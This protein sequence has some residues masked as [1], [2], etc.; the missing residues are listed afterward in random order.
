MTCHPHYQ[1]HLQIGIIFLL[2]FSWTS[3]VQAQQISGKVIDKVGEALIGVNIVIKGD[4]SRGTTTDF[5]GS[6]ELTANQGETLVFSYTG[7]LT[8]EILIGTQ[9]SFDLT[10]E[11]NVE[12][13]DE[14]VVIGY[15]V[16]KKSD[17]TG[18]V[19]SVDVGDVQKLA[20]V[21]VT[22]NL[23][24]KVAG[25][26]I[27]PN[28]GAPGVGSSVRIRGVGSFSNADPLYVVDGFLTGD[29]S[30][31]APTDIHSIEVLKDASATAIYG[32][33]GANGVILITTKKGA[34]GEA[35]I[36]INSYVGTQ[37]PW[38]T[39]DL[40]N[41]QQYAEIY[42]EAVAG[43]DGDLNGIRDP[44]RRAWIEAA[45]SGAEPGTDWQDYIFRDNAIIQSHNVS[46][47]GSEGKIKY[48]A[49][50]T[51]FDQEGIVHLTEGRRIQAN[52]GAEMDVKPFLTLGGDLKYS[53]NTAVAFDESAFGGPLTSALVKDPI[54]P[55][56]NYITGDWERTGL[57][58][59]PNPGRRLD[60]QQFN[61]NEW[62]RYVI[63]GN[64]VVKFTPNLRLTSQITLDQR[65]SSFSRYT[66][67]Q[68]VV[69]GK[70]IG[71]DNL[72]VV[73]TNESVPIS[74][75]SETEDFQWVL[76]NT[77][78][79]TYDMAFGDHNLSVMAGLESYQNEFSRNSLFI[80]DVPQAEV[81][82][83]IS[84]GANISSLQGQDFASRYTLLSYFGRLNYTFSDRYLLTATVRRDGSSKFPEQ[85][86]WGTFPSFSL[87]WNLHNESF[88][89]A[90]NILTR[91]KLRG[92]WGQVGNQN[93][94]GPYDYVSLLT[95]GAQYSFDN[96]QGFQGLA[97]TQ[98][99]ASSLKWEVS[100]MINIGLDLGLWNDKVTLSVDYFDKDTRDLLVGSLPTPIFAGAN[101]PASNAASMT[102]RGLEL[103]GEYRDKI[104]KLSFSVGGNI[105]FIDNEVTDLG[106]GDL[107]LGGSENGKMGYSATRTI[108][109]Y[110]FATFWA[111]QTNGVFQNEE[112]VQR[113][114]ATNSN[115]EPI[116][117][118][119][120]V[121]SNIEIDNRG[122]YFGFYT[123]E[124]G[125][126]I[127]SQ[128]RPIQRNAAPGDL[129][130]VDQNFDGRIDEE[131]LIPMGSA[132]PNFTY[133]GY[134][135]LNY[136]IIDLSIAFTGSQG[137]EIANVRSFWL[138]NSSPLESNL[139]INRL[140]RWRGEGTSETEPRV[141]DDANDN[142]LYSNRFIEDG[143][144][145]RLRN[146]QIGV[147]LP[148]SITDK[149]NL[150]RV[151]FY[152]SADNLFTITDYSGLDP[153][154]GIT[155]GDPF[156]P[157]VDY[158]T[159]PVP[160][161]IIFGTNISF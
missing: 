52:F 146:L 11:E 123:D 142:G 22:R 107:I 143:S 135:N 77:N 50:G 95:P 18:S 140:N 75:L 118:F 3:I 10:L 111:L 65:R 137:N 99:P 155:R 153:E 81:Q 32:S 64:A 156:A 147:T 119:G 129:I 63:T 73:S 36:E 20:S 51:F 55:V 42:L 150:D 144:F 105:A 88:F 151:R 44:S 37:S 101:G 35:V 138:Q 112:E 79:L 34:Q 71:A 43:I 56:Y 154:I 133:G 58:D 128:A 8:Q 68:T 85:N 161:T 61:T 4:P 102:N 115:G 134:I 76:Q 60:A 46:I 24:G 59:H 13:L 100:E 120:N 33:R 41:A 66:P 109:G 45:L 93:P 94:I 97:T 26:T 25:L 19:A 92:G 74:S 15:G 54:N 117:V 72:P 39:I 29:I 121:L 1:S 67:V 31:I 83:Y 126:Q 7:Y 122:R 27:L 16:A 157:G 96:Q 132:V 158:G 89:P 38:K 21:D 141:T 160:R 113:H 5:D 84:L 49:G 17:V 69:E 108:V 116:D 104:G 70:V 47:R 12:V 110:P 86:R 53:N 23:Q 82:R 78:Y 136:G 14:I 145:F 87:G 148:T 48:V 62:D 98:L 57:N 9:T 130:Y 30:N 106:A 125:E 114:I 131:D 90:S 159:Y 139:A 152:L 149:V 40:L 124:N 127:R 103:A 91:A 28:S 2:M 80:Q 6:F